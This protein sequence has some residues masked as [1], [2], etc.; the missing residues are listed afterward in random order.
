[1]ENIGPSG[2]LVEWKLST[3]ANSALAELLS[4]FPSFIAFLIKV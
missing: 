3:K 1:M 2:E 4:S